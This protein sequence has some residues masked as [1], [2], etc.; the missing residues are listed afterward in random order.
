MQLDNSRRRCIVI[1]P[2]PSFLE[3][4][5]R[6]GWLGWNAMV[7]EMGRQRGAPQ[8]RDLRGVLAALVTAIG[9]WFFILVGLVG[10]VLKI[11]H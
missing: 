6:S 3:A 11:L 10:L 1:K 7:T 8:V 2:T 4:I 5:R 9:I